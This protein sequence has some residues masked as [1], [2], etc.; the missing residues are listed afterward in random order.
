MVH[1]A[2][3]FLERT[4]NQLPSVQVD[5]ALVQFQ[6][7][8]YSAP[9]V[10]QRQAEGSRHAIWMTPSGRDESLPLIRRHMFPFAPVGRIHPAVLHGIQ[11]N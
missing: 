6:R 7:F 2:V 3:T 1:S 11:R 10:S 9:G 8:R 4:E 5:A